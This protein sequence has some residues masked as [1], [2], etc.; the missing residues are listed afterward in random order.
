MSKKLKTSV[1]ANKNE[2]LIIISVKL[3]KLK[4]H[5]ARMQRG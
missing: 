5:A 4:T 2:T 3:Q 1:S